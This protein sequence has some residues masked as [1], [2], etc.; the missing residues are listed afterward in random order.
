VEALKKHCCFSEKIRQRSDCGLE[1]VAMKNQKKIEKI[2]DH[3][4][5]KRETECLGDTMAHD[6]VFN[7]IPVV[8]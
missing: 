1:D 8:A 5:N 4:K 2:K 3:E 6:P 7:D